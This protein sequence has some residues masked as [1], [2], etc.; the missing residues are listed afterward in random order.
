M[1]RKVRRLG[2]LTSLSCK[3][4]WWLGASTVGLRLVRLWLHLMVE[5]IGFV[6][7]LNVGERKELR[8]IQ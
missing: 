7:R 3:R 4:E 6:E 2:G 1:E 5:P 8:K